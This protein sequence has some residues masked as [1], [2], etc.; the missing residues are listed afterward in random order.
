MESINFDNLA[1][2]FNPQNHNS[3]H[4]LMP[5][6]PYRLIIVG[7]SGCGKSNLLFNMLTQWLSYQT[8]WV[9]AKDIEE[10]KYKLL[11]EFIEEV[12]A[13]R[14]KKD[15]D[16]EL[17]E[18]NMSDDIDDIPDPSTID[19]TRQHLFVFDDMITEK[20]QEGISDIFI[21]GRKRN[22]STIYLSHNY[23]E[24]PRNI[25]KNA[26]YLVLF[27]LDND[28]EVKTMIA[29][30]HGSRLPTDEFMKLYHHCTD[31][32]HGYLVIDNET[33]DVDCGGFR[34]GWDRFYKKG[35][36]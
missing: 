9:F 35:T 20:H 14:L 36:A 16:A 24:T 29:K 7:G 15:P 21:R 1:K 33:D 32:K 34:C 11:P 8:L 10:D 5:R 3:G 17:V 6:V 13:K 4:F 25:R 22:I 28:R 18:L 26:K 27:A 23:S 30:S 31:N 19:A 2:P 12:N